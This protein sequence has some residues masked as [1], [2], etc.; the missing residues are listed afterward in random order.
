MNPLR[1]CK[2]STKLWSISLL[3]SAVSAVIV[4]YLI[5]KGA[6][7][8]IDFARLERLGNEVQA[9]LERL[10]EALPKHHAAVRAAPADPA[11]LADAERATDRAFDDVAAALAR[12]GE[13][14]QFTDAGLA[15]RKR[16][17][18]A[19]RTVRDEWDR[20]KAAAAKA[21]PASA[22]LDEQYAHLVADVRTM[23]THVGDTSNLILDPD[24]DSY[25]LM[26][27][28]LV[29]L[30]QTQDRLAQVT[31]FGQGALRAGRVTP[32]QQVQLAVYA[33]MLQESD[34]DRVSADVQTTLNEDKNFYGVS[35]TLQADLPAATK[36]YADAAA[37][38]VQL[39]RQL[40]AGGKTEV[41]PNEYAAAGDRARDESFRL[42][43]VASRELDALLQARIKSYAA[44]RAWGFAMTAVALVVVAAVVQLI[45]RSITRPLRAVA[46]ELGEGAERVAS[47]S[48]QIASTG[49]SLAQNASEQAASLEETTSALEEMSSMTR[50]N[51]G[52]A[53]AANGLSAEAKAAADRCNA[54]MQKMG[55]AIREIE[56]SAGETA[57]IVR[58]I[59]EI[60]FQTN[61]LALNAAVEAARAGEAGKGFAVVA[62]EVRNLAM[63]SA[64]AAKNTAALIEGSVQNAKSGV[65]ISADVAKTLDE[66]TAGV[67][68]VNQLISEIATASHEQSQGIGQVNT[69][70]QQMDK[71]TQSNAANAE[72][73]AS[74][75]E[76]LSTQAATLTTIVARLRTQVDGAR[77]TA[78]S[79]LA[80]YT[81]TAST[82][83]QP[84]FP[85]R[86]RAAA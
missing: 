47:A 62:E 15:A 20:L 77:S 39:T 41:T 7:K 75:S 17:H 36:A 82:P 76:E 65:A 29:A 3:Y 57:K 48:N 49:K 14:L 5:A 61:L 51:A 81:T 18:V 38:F 13:Q 86:Y 4:V 79:E 46:T 27:V 56:K 40:A 60:A 16:E 84:G 71:V 44:S 83:A 43:N 50:Q 8:D 11:R 31:A 42:W 22:A 68:K 23:I 64:E 73:S 33:A 35:P 58:V 70:V 2:I 74:A 45:A 30:P 80:A 24:L 66:I 1:H 55:A 63:R 21:G 9:P 85:N 25:Y 26:D 6:N 10:L 28:T 67:A 78:A 72:E 34:L 59:D 69:A 53:A 37:H 12:A 52:T 54:A 19:L 32:E